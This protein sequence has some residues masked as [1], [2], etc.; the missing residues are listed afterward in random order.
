MR[1]RF[2]ADRGTPANRR[3]ARCR[4]RSPRSD[5]PRERNGA[6]PRSGS[7]MARQ[8]QGIVRS[9]GFARDDDK[10]MHT[11]DPCW[12]PDETGACLP[13][14]PRFSAAISIYGEVCT[15]TPCHAPGPSRGRDKGERSRILGRPGGDRSRGGADAIRI[16]QADTQLKLSISAGIYP[17]EFVQKTTAGR[18]DGV[19][20]ARIRWW[21]GGIEMAE[22]RAGSSAE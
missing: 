4:W 14:E 8:Q 15:V 12:R 20:R 13:H 1:C 22:D 17:S 9:I 21:V 5:T 18:R 16:A 11:G 6:R 3:S 7:A 2:R 10:G 19:N